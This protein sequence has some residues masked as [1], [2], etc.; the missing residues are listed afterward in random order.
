MPDTV[1]SRPDPR[2]GLAFD[3]SAWPAL[4]GGGRSLVA[5]GAGIRPDLVAEAG[6]GSLVAD[7]APALGRPAQHL[8]RFGPRTPS[9]ASGVPRTHC[10]VRPSSIDG[11]NVLTTIE[12][13]LGG[14]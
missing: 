11:F 13:A 6:G 7:R 9:R 8:L 2:D 14:A 5:P 4:R 1:A 3:P 10:G 12:A